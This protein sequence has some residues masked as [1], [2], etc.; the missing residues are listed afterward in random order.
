LC[1]L[2]NGNE[3]GAAY[4]TGPMPASHVGMP[5]GLVEMTKVTEGTQMP[6]TPI[7]NQDLWV[8]A[9]TWQKRQVGQGTVFMKLS[10]DGRRLDWSHD[11]GW[12]PDVYGAGLSCDATNY[13]LGQF[14]PTSNVNI[15]IDD[16]LI[17]SSAT[18]TTAMLRTNAGTCFV[19]GY[20]TISAETFPPGNFKIVGTVVKG[21]L[22]ASA[23]NT[24]AVSACTGNYRNNPV[25]WSRNNQYTDNFYTTSEADNKASILSYGYEYRPDPFYLPA[26]LVGSYAGD[27]SQFRRFFKGAPQIEH[28]YSTNP[29]ETSVVI[30]Y[31]YINEKVEGYVYK[32]NKPG[33]TPLYRYA[34]FFPATGDLQHYY[35][36][37][38]GDPNAA[39]YV[40]EGIIGYVCASRN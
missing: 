28:F 39:G 4:S 27:Q 12:V 31:G 19:S 2:A 24:F 11:T 3:L 33:T 14:I 36:I 35:T 23:T 25:F 8:A 20:N 40:Y 9:E 6:G 15:Y 1:G 37:R 22:L 29:S 18:P 17:G 21:P 38:G 7:V 13:G 16:R 26:Q 5:T 34:Q 30:G 10:A 32:T